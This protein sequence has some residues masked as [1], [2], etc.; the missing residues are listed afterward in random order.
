[1]YIFYTQV[2]SQSQVSFQ[3]D[4]P[5]NCPWTAIELP[6]NCHWTALELTS[7]WSHA[8]LSRDYFSERDLQWNPHFFISLSLCQYNLTTIYSEY[9]E[10]AVRF[11][12]AFVQLV[13]PWQATFTKASNSRNRRIRALEA[14]PCVINLWYLCKKCENHTQQRRKA[15]VAFFCTQLV[16]RRNAREAAGGGISEKIPV[17]ARCTFSYT[18]SFSLY[19]SRMPTAIISTIAFRLDICRA[20]MQ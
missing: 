19:S 3:A 1:M 6:L 8:M 10:Y 2:Q 15:I 11:L 9:S 18:S 14:D 13:H 17:V 20:K 16:N 4:L 5:L 12:K 7:S